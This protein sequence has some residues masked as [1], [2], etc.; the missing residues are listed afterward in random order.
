[1]GKFHLYEFLK[2]CNSK[3]NVKCFLGFE[4]AI[5]LVVIILTAIRA[6][7]DVYGWSWIVFI[8]NLLNLVVLGIDIK[9]FGF[10]NTI[11]LFFVLFTESISL[12][13]NILVSLPPTFLQSYPTQ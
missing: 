8:I 4:L 13:A 1:M 9:F 6:V 7:T 5:Q 3:S 12:A 10:S 11:S 2:R